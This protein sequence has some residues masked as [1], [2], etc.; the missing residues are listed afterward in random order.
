MGCAPNWRW[1]CAEESQQWTQISKVAGGIVFVA[2]TANMMKILG[3]EHHHFSAPEFSFLRIRTKP[4]PWGGDCG[5]FEG[6]CIAKEA[7]AAADN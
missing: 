6:E 1:D 3:G 5:P 4:F 7:A 2:T